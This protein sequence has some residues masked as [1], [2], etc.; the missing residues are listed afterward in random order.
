MSS[1]KT[2]IVAV[3]PYPDG[4]YAIGEVDLETMD[5]EIRQA[6]I[7]HVMPLCAKGD[8][9]ATQAKVGNY[10]AQWARENEELRRREYEDKHRPVAVAPEIDDDGMPRVLRQS[11]PAP[12]RGWLQVIG[13]KG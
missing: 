3:M 8:I 2:W 1:P 7:S 5:V 11:T 13:G 10:I 4:G 9:E 6:I 12:R